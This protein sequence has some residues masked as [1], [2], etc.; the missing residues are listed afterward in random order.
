MSL[1]TL[2]ELAP[3]A[4][5]TG[6][7]QTL[8][9]VHNARERANYFSL[10][11]LP[12]IVTLPDFEL[13]L[14]FD[15]ARFGQ[16]ATPQVGRLVLAIDKADPMA[17]LAWK[18]AVG[19]IRSAPWPLG[20]SD[21]AD[22]AFGVPSFFRVESIEL[23]D[24]LAT[25][26]L[27]DPGQ[28]LRRPA[29][30]RRFG[31]TGN[32]LL[33]DAANVDLKGRPVPMGWGRMLSVPGLLVDRANNIWLFLGRAATSAQ[34]FYDGGAAFTLGTARAD[35]A[36]LRANSPAA[37]TVDYCLDAAGLMLA[38]PWTT[39][40]YPFT[41]DLTAGLTQPAAIAAAIIAARTTLVLEAGT[42]AA[43]TGLMG[44]PCALYIDDERPI[45]AALDQIFAGL[46]GFWR[47]TSA[48]RI[49]FGRLAHTAPAQTFEAFQIG[50]ITRRRIIM[51]TRRRSLGYAANNR[52][53]SEG[54][55]AAILLVNNIAGLGVLATQDDVDFASQVTGGSKPADNATRNIP[56]GDWALAT[57][58][59]SGDFVNAGGNAY[60]AITNHVASALNKP[61]S[62]DWALLVSGGGAGAAGD[63]VAIVQIWK[64]GATAPAGPT[65]DAVFDFSGTLTEA[66]PG[67]LNGWTLAVPVTNGQAAWSRYA[68]ARNGGSA[69]TITSGE[70]SAA[71]KALDDGTDGLTFSAQPDT[72]VLLAD[73]AGALL[74]GE[75]PRTVQLSVFDGAT[76]VTASASYSTSVSSVGIT[77][78][79]GGAFRIDSIS[80]ESGHF[81]VTATVAGRSGKKRI[82]AQKVR[83]GRSAVSAVDDSLTINT[84]S[85]YGSA[86][87]GPMVLAVSA[88]TIN[89]SVN[90]GYVGDSAAHTLAGKVRYRT[91]PGIGAW[92]DIGSETVALGSAG[93]GEPDTLSFSRTLAGPPS[94][95]NWEFEYLNRSTLGSAAS[96][97]GAPV[98]QVS[99]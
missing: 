90:H 91:T 5:A 23:G 66:S 56:R 2:I 51:P 79:G 69:D 71:V 88:G 20:P 82:V 75:L 78:L 52:V 14:G 77:N 48:N 12:T 43:F 17:A 16:G 54:D 68:G 65:G 37:A 13:D 46:G 28:E 36:A 93:P 10:Q 8:R 18:S 29:I 59:S 40:A 6:A 98:F 74:T 95:T 63:N 38:R 72:V 96:N 22:G 25:L 35:L 61:P 94:P 33:D 80:A 53:H 57:S 60:A 67:N 64:R 26:T 87:G 73:S 81:D 3:R 44:A 49:A 86:N 27:I 97:S 24:G 32:A 9:F 84:S 15:G 7:T 42:E 70:W 47:L 62:A 1:V 50:G 30:E 4:V 34:G 21:P 39:P 11:W 19:N 76:D 58:Y 85:T 45:G 55:I 41:A 83:G 31:T 99:Q 89:L 92:T